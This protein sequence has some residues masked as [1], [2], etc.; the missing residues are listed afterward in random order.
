MPMVPTFT[1]PTPSA[2][3]A[4][5]AA[6]ERGEDGV[7]YARD[8]EPVSYLEDGNQMCFEL[9]EDSFWFKHRGACLAAVVRR[10]PPVGAIYAFNE[11]SSF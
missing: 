1:S 11:I 9:E 6:L 7:W 3:I 2:P 5:P 4:L 8:R 10:F